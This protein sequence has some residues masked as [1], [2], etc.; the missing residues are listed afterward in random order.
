MVVSDQAAEALLGVERSVSGLRWRDRVGDHRTAMAISQQ[1]RVP[2]VIGRVLAARGVRSESA[3]QFLDPKLR[4]LMPDPSQL[5]DMD[6]AVSR[7][8]QAVV[9]SEKIA[10]FGDYDVD[11]ATASALLR[12]FLS[13]VGVNIDVYIPDRM[14]EGYGPTIDAFRKLRAEGAKVVVTVDCGTTAHDALASAKVIG[15]DVIVLDH[16]LAGPALPP[17]FALVNPNRLDDDSG[18]GALAAVG[19]TYLLVVALNRALRGAGFFKDK[20]EPDLMAWLD[21]VALGTVCDV[22]PLT[23]LNRALVRQGLKVLARR[24]NKGLAAL[25]DV[26]GIDGRPECYHLG[27]VLGPRINAGG[28][29]GESDLGHRLLTTSDATDAA[30]VAA[31][32]NDLNLERRT[33]ESLNVEQAFAQVEASGQSSPAIVVQDRHWHLGVIGLVASRLVERYKRPSLV[34]AFDGDIGRGSARSVP[35]IDIGAM[36]T[37]AHQCDL[38]LGGGGHPMAAGFTIQR[39]KLDEF[40]DFV[41]KR[42]VKQGSLADAPSLGMDGVLALSAAR[43]ELIETFDQAGPYGAGNPMPR[44]AFAKV[45]VVRADRVGSG[46][47]VRCI[48]AGDEGTRLKGIAFRVA[49]QP[50]GQ[51]LLNAKSLHIAGSL[52]HNNWGGRQEVQLSIDDV[53]Y[54]ENSYQSI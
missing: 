41:E 25:G 32:L 14:R 20:E 6:R 46:D 50:L 47:H 8:V 45:K 18:Q 28:R 26:A 52:Q 24:N 54:P 39:A 11:G 44:F 38:L 16:H 35:N 1:L 12:R 37:A 40:R 13:E 9:E 15:L 27:F 10:V 53:A 17:C 4:D 2:D 48:L 3:E 22:V 30:Q 34:I 43:S 33:I 19:V 51:A 7:L 49:D 42:A 29:V 31:R 5:I 36:I 23:G 21:L